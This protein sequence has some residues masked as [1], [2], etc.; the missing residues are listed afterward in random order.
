MQNC[1]ASQ[2]DIFLRTNTQK[3]LIQKVGT[4]NWDPKSLFGVTPNRI[5]SRISEV[6]GSNL[7]ILQVAGNFATSIVEEEDATSSQNQRSENPSV[8]FPESPFLSSWKVSLVVIK[9]LLRCMWFWSSK[10]KSS[11]IVFVGFFH[12]F[13]ALPT[14][15]PLSVAPDSAVQPK[16]SCIS[17]PLD[18]P[19]VHS[20]TRQN[21]VNTTDKRPPREE[22]RLF[23]KCLGCILKFFE[24]LGSSASFPG[25]SVSHVP[26]GPYLEEENR[27]PTPRV[28]QRLKL[29][30]ARLQ[31]Q[32]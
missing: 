2:R 20:L 29:T 31:D 28:L 13:G 18:C 12:I 15:T 25:S 32:R 21:T 5:F 9:H 4:R 1:L 26:K 16:M 27:H 3:P 7:R 10:I 24:I 17:K 22:V 19:G 11:T 14:S 8:E 30:S 6:G 23:P